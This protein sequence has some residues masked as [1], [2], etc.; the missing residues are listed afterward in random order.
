VLSLRQLRAKKHLCHPSQQDPFGS[1]ERNSPTGRRRCSGLV[2]T[3]M[4]VTY[5]PHPE[6]ATGVCASNL[7]R[8]VCYDR[9]ILQISEA[10]V[11]H[12]QLI[13]VLAQVFSPYAPPPPPPLPPPPSPTPPNR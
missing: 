9:S 8:C 11:H 7:I 1:K 10:F 4:P 12:S 6:D 2:A 3:C 13:D 5:D